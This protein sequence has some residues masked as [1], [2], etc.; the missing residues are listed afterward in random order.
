M[1]V[2]EWEATQRE[3]KYVG[4]LRPSCADLE[5][6]VE[7]LSVFHNLKKMDDLPFETVWSALHEG[8]GFAQCGT[9]R[10]AVSEFGE[11][12][13]ALSLLMSLWMWLLTEV[14]APIFATK[15]PLLSGMYPT[16]ITSYPPPPTPASNPSQCPLITT[17]LNPAPLAALL[18]FPPLLLAFKLP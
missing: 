3:G 4:S 18:L 16:P 13:K 15:S 14:W 12:I 8:P 10:P 2:E 9:G 7:K 1:R 6:T 11:K 5:V 17:K